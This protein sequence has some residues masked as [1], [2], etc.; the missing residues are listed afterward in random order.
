MKPRHFQSFASSF[1]STMAYPA[2]PIC[3]HWPVEAFFLHG[4]APGFLIVSELRIWALSSGLKR[5][6]FV[7]IRSTSKSQASRQKICFLP[8][9][10]DWHMPEISRF[11]GIVIQIYYG[12]HPPPHFHANYAGQVAKIDIDTLA[13]IDGSL[14]A[15]ARGLVTEWASLHQDELREAFRKAASLEQPP[16]IAP[17]P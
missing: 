4:F 7:L 15:R 17:L 13:L 3:R 8:F 14:P 16:K 6:I 5:S 9:T 10:A 12:D 2:S 11:Y 1:V